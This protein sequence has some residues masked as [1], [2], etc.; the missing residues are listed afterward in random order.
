MRALDLF[1][2]TGWGVACA[3]LGIEEFGVDN[4]PAVIATRAANGMTTVFHD[5]WDGLHDEGLVPEHELLIGSPPC[6]TFSIAGSGKG[7]DALSKV[8]ELIAEHA[9]NRVDDMRAFAL[10]Q[11]DER[12]A[13]VLAPL[14]YAARFRPT[15]VVLEQVP[16]VLPVWEACAAELE[17]MGYS[18]WTG[19]LQA[20]QYGV[21]QT[22]KR[23][24]LIARRDGVEAQPPVPTHSRF[25]VRTPERTDPG[26][27]P[28]VSMSTA[29]GWGMT[30]RPYFSL[31]VGTAAGGT[32]PAALGG[33]GARKALLGERRA[34]RWTE[35]TPWNEG[36][37]G[38]A[39][40]S[41][42]PAPTVN[43]D[44]RLAPRGCKHPVAGCCSANPNGEL[45]GR[46]FPEG[47]VRVTVEQASALQ[48]YPDGFQWVG[49]R[50]QSFQQIGN[51]VPPLLARH[52]LEA[53]I[54]R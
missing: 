14:A 13:L 11:G 50:G 28:W 41:R 23:A 22:R 1:A 32:D 18:T 21:P 7:R 51:A 38:A 10:E 44:P 47:T 29:L 2:G 24:V 16:P 31:A 45:V 8:L 9:Y 25:Y 36:V 6:Q 26:T 5:V 12:T 49:G 53:A 19:F 30:E 20:E 52:I 33:S 17:Q 40:W 35:G 48:S 4:D 15:Y 46:Q 37:T 54:A 3:E 27:Q 39:Q 42:S 43:G 34:G